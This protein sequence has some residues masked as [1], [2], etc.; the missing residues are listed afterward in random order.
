MPSLWFSSDLHLGHANIIQYCKRP[1]SCLDE[2]HDILIETWNEL[3]TA[4]DQV[5]ILG[6]LALGRL[7]ETLPLVSRLAGHKVLVPGNHD[8]CWQHHQKRV[9]DTAA[10]GVDWPSVYLEHLQEIRHDELLQHPDLPARVLLSHL[11]YV[12]DSG[13]KERFRHARPV[14]RGEWLVHGHVHDVWRQNGR[15]INVGIDAW[16]G[17]PV[18]VEEV[19]ELINSGPRVLAPLP[20]V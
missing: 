13:P 1:F 19:A 17:R 5:V 14:D 6:D 16:G 7:E 18:L 8:R 15:Q 12:G 9:P 3:I 2:M 10:P 4:E 20:W 11:P